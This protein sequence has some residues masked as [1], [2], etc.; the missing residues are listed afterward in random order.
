[1][2]GEDFAA[3]IPESRQVR[4]VCVPRA[5]IF[6]SDKVKQLLVLLVAHTSSVKARI[7]GAEE[8][9]PLI[10]HG[11]KVAAASSCSEGTTDVRP[12]IVSIPEL[13]AVGGMRTRPGSIGNECSTLTKSYRVVQGGTHEGLAHRGIGIVVTGS[14]VGDESIHN[15]I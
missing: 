6:L 9:E 5:A 2:I 10:I 7:L 12:R 8:I 15:T 13:M 1:M 3:S 4:I 14:H 11:G